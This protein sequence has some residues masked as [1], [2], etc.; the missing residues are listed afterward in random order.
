[1][2]IKD[3][4]YAVGRSGFFNRD[5]AAIKAGVRADG[6]AYPGKPL[7]PGFEKIVQPRSQR[8]ISTGIFDSMMM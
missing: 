7:S 1:M 4:I 8:A 6:F 5:L 3:V 2:K